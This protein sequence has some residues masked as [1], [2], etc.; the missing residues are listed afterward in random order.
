MFR[1]GQCI[2]VVGS[3]RENGAGPRVGSIG[4]I[5]KKGEVVHT[6]ASPGERR[7][8]QPAKITFVRFGFEQKQRNESKSV[9]LTIPMHVT[10]NEKWMRAVLKGFPKF[11]FTPPTYWQTAMTFEDIT[12]TTPF[13]V[14]VPM[15]F[16]SVVAHNDLLF[17]AWLTG[18]TNDSWVQEGL[19]KLNANKEAAK[20]SFKICT[21]M[22]EFMRDKISSYNCVPRDKVSIIASNPGHRSDAFRIIRIA[23]MLGERN[24]YAT[25]VEGFH[26]FI[27]NHNR[28]G[29]NL[30]TRT[31][32]RVARNLM[33]PFFRKAKLDVLRAYPSCPKTGK[34]KKGVADQIERN[35]RLLQNSTHYTLNR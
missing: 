11:D 24:A 20:K 7:F 27:D 16:M 8:V 14:A 31:W 34:T 30:E 4:F 22:L 5:A 9:M 15:P 28:F 35:I 29:G 18:I 25:E 6:S 19:N 23:R 10:P 3:T 26:S 21:G 12:G 2:A 17:G 33:Y 13:I 32:K 1:S